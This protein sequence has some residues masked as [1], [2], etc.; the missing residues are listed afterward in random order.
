LKSVNTIVTMCKK[1][2]SLCFVC[3]AEMRCTSGCEELDDLIY[4]GCVKEENDHI[5]ELSYIITSHV[6]C[7]ETHEYNYCSV[8]EIQEMHIEEI[9]EIITGQNMDV[10]LNLMSDSNNCLIH[11]PKE[12]LHLDSMMGMLT[13]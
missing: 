7:L 12:D 4:S 1:M 8:E 6:S 5:N 10:T 11:Y 13:R 9:V 3:H 2:I